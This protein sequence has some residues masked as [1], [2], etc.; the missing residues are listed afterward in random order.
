MSKNSRSSNRSVSEKSANDPN[1][2]AALFVDHDAALEYLNSR[3][4]YERVRPGPNGGQGEFKLQ[5][6]HALMEALDNPHLAVKMVHI[7]GSKGKGSV[8]SMLTSCLQACGYTT[9]MFTS[10][11]LVDERERIQL[12]G[13]PVDKP[14]FGH[15]LARCRDAAMTV[16]EEHGEVTYFEI[17]TAA[18]FVVFAMEAVDVAVIETGLG[19][20]LDSTNV[21]SPAVVGLTEIQLEHTDVLGERIE[22][23]A[24]EKA[25][26][27][28]PG[29]VAI[30]VPQEE[31]VTEVFK[32]KAEEANS[33][34][35]TLE[36]EVMYSCRFQSSATRGP[37]PRVCVGD[38]PGG[39]EHI[40]VPLYGQHQAPN[41]GLAL[42]ILMELGSQGFDLPERCISA[43]M[44]QSPREGKLEQIHDSP[45]IVIDG[46]HTPESIHE[47][48]R[49]C[50]AHLQYD[51]L[52]VIFGCNRDKRVDE[53]LAELE[54]G[55]DKLIFTRSAMTPR[56]MKPEDLLAQFMERDHPIM[57][58]SSPTIKES[59]N[60][61][62]SAVGPQ[63]MILVLGSFYLAGE[64]KRLLQAAHQKT[65]AA[66]N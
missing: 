45:R 66:A 57:A 48:L 8:C 11:H 44:E 30:S 2:K 43:G 1:A 6:M 9:G 37:H 50:G 4:N 39:F 15:A 22:L 60:I 5:R 12:S 63:D 16:E 27:I 10:P 34:L 14:T 62:A 29:V 33:V 64:A 59:I 17:L 65:V 51:S 20:R 31:S 23:I 46:A 52:V 53:M 58:Q 26:I 40:S 18:A 54:R 42:A 41:C 7:A 38:L 55:A 32:Q 21:V 24:A 19:G 3:V 28:K 13:Q 61:A 36:D 47:T 35:K 56:A 25:G 49:A